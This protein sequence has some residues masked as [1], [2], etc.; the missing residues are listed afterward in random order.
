MKKLLIAAAGAFGLAQG[1]AS[2]AIT[3][4]TSEAAFLADTGALTPENFNSFTGEPSFANTS[5]ATPSGVSLVTTGTLLNDP[6]RNAINQP[7]NAS[8]AVDGTAH[9][10]VVLNSSDDIFTITLPTAVN[11]F[12][13][14]FRALNDLE[15]RTD[16]V[17]NSESIIMPILASGT[18][19]S[20]FGVT[21]DVAFTSVSFVLVGK[22]DGFLV[23]NVYFGDAE[24]VP[25]PAAGL[26]MAGAFA[27][28]AGLRRRKG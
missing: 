15:R 3:T 8:S 9:A 5:L 13:A 14:S 23:D 1:A 11:A 2:A 7:L 20:F 24:V 17:V 28:L 22:T 19:V 16:L 4:Y 25:I 6:L 27:G 26:L 21:S 12:A 10:N 18:S